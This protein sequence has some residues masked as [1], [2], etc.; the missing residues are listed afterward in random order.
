[1]FKVKK[2]LAALF[3]KQSLPDIIFK[4]HN[5]VPEQLKTKIF[6]ID[7]LPVLRVT[8]ALGL[9]GYFDYICWYISQPI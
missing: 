4:L 5:Q 9:F 2:F 3:L 6:Q 1:M 8:T 7:F